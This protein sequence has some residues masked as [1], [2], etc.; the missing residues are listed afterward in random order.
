MTTSSSGLYGTFGQANYGAAKMVLIDLMQALSIEAAKYDIRVNCLAPAGT[1]MTDQLLP[2]EAK[3]LL[4]M[5]RVSPGLLWLV[6]DDATTRAIPCVQGGG[7]GHFAR[8]YII[9]TGG[10]LIGHGDD[11]ADQ[12]AA[13]WD[14]I[15]DRGSKTVVENS[16]T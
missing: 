3:A 9:L 13:R 12:A 11:E 1:A 4:L 7:G 5:E 10:A 2:K 16:S 15:S 8:A 6:A 14:E